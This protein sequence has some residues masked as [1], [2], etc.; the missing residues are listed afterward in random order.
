MV[1][2]TDLHFGETDEDDANNQRLMG[3]ILDSEKPDLV[4]MTGDLISG[5]AWDG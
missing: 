1:Q 2:F 4:V 5:Y 3:E